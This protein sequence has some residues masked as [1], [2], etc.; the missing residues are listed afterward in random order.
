MHAYIDN[1]NFVMPLTPKQREKFKQTRI[2]G[3]LRTAAEGTD[4]G[5][6]KPRQQHAFLG[7]PSVCVTA[8][9]AKDRVILW[10]VHESAWNGQTAADTYAGPVL[11]AL[12]R[13]WGQ[14]KPGAWRCPADAVARSGSGVVRRSPLIDR[15]DRACGACRS[16][17]AERHLPC[18]FPL[19][20]SYT[21]VEDGDRKGNQSKKGIDA[22]KQAGIK[23]MTLP[24]RTPSLMP[25][26]FAVWKAIED[27]VVKT[28][29]RGHESKAAFLSRLH[30]CAKELP[31]GFVRR[32]INRMKP[33][34]QGIIDAQGYAPKN[35]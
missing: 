5:F 17:L 22:K 6:T 2:T 19:L 32:V 23:A 24:P 13:T 8:A 30:K 18:A 4:R 7:I 26:D 11:T 34:I 16:P 31:K 28:S 9:V 35:D 12:N 20:R 33:N 1:K 27:N 15:F 10:H 21:I 25:L 29:P 14:R 3:H